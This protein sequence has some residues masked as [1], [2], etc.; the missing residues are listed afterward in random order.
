MR[1]QTGPLEFSTYCVTNMKI[2]TGL[3][4]V[5]APGRKKA[6]SFS[7]R[8]RSPASESRPYTTGEPLVTCGEVI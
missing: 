6:P 2:P 8:A 3:F 1:S 7:V 4:A 5:P